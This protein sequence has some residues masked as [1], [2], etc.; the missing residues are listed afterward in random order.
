MTVRP[1]ASDMFPQVVKERT[2]L[3]EGNITDSMASPHNKRVSASRAAS[4]D[5]GTARLPLSARRATLACTSEH[6]API[7]L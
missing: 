5:V 2:S 4:L 6:S 3:A 7:R 1:V